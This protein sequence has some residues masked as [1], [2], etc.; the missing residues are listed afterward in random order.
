MLKHE[1]TSIEMEKRQLYTKLSELEVQYGIKN[2]DTSL[3]VSMLFDWLRIGTFIVL[4]WIFA[5][6]FFVSWIYSCTG[7]ILDGERI[8]FASTGILTFIAIFYSL[9]YSKEGG[10]IVESIEKLVASKIKQFKMDVKKAIQ[11]SQINKIRLEVENI[12]KAMNRIK[13]LADVE[14]LLLF[15]VFL[16]LFSII[17]SLFE[18]FPAT[19]ISW[20]ACGTGF[21]LSSGIVLMWTILHRIA[22]KFN[23]IGIK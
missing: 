16:L 14:L 17:F 19:I 1:T 18:D 11:K 15:T 12:T 7:F 4:L 13:L 20:T 23:L 10:I 8:I 21:V 9:I 5:L 6:C 22:K 3:D 2:K